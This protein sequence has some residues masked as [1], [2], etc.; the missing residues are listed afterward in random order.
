[1]WFFSMNLILSI[2]Y[3][4][5]S[6]DVPNTRED[7]KTNVEITE[8]VTTD[9]LTQQKPNGKKKSQDQEKG[10][11]K[12]Q[13]SV[14]EHHR[15]GERS[16]GGRAAFKGS[17]YRPRSHPECRVHISNIP[18]EYRWQDLKD[19]FRSEGLSLLSLLVF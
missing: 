8:E 9:K 12:D 17:V 10:R 3:L 16:R 15:R 5:R 19:L 6:C 11:S 14:R 2:L 1:M 7:D 4:N 18:Y 13:Q